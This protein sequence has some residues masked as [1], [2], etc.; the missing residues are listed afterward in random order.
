MTIPEAASL[1]LQAGAMGQGGDVFVLDMGTPVKIVELARK[2]IHLSGLEVRDESNPEG[3]IEIRYSGLRAGEKL[4]E[5]L[6]IGENVSGTEHPLI[7]RAEEIELPW[8]YLRGKLEQ[9]DDAFHQF[10]YET[11]RNVLLEVVDGYQPTGGI[12]DQVWVKSR[13]AI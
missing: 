13:D 6:L 7:M 9:L 12:C 11:V 10:D 3:D 4:Y 1:V 8:P 2:M 5:E